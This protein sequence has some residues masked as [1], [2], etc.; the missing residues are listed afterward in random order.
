MDSVRTVPKQS[1][2]N[3]LLQ[4]QNQESET[5]C[6]SFLYDTPDKEVGSAARPMIH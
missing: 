3:G 1:F 2:Q 5:L 6:V 4:N